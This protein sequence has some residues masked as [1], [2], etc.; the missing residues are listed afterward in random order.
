MSLFNPQDERED[1]EENLE[2]TH[3]VE[4]PK[5]PPERLR[6]SF[7]NEYVAIMGEGSTA[8]HMKIGIESK[9]GMDMKT[10]HFDYFYISKK[11]RS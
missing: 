9:V 2:A 11:K 5:S 8:E 10:P 3:H 4:K 1:F 7:A 6:E